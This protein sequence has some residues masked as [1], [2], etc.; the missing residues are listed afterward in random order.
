GDGI[1]VEELL[2]ALDVALDGFALLRDG[3]VVYANEAAGK[4]ADP[5]DLLRRHGVP[6][7]GDDGVL[8]VRST[9]VAADLVAVSCR[10]ISER[11]QAEEQRHIA[12]DLQHALL[13]ATLPPVEGA[14][15]AVRYLPWTSGADVGG[16]WYDL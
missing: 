14:R 2:A 16:D 7:H 13:P 9:R 10:D 3:A 11:A 6:Y 1:T 4:L 15:H 8:E 5:V 12:T